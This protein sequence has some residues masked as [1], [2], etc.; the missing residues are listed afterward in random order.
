M[1]GPLSCFRPSENEDQDRNTT[2]LTAKRIRGTA[3]RRRAAYLAVRTNQLILVSYATA[4]SDR[5]QLIDL[6]RRFRVMLI[7]DESHRVKRFR[8]DSWA[9][10]LL[11]IAKHA[12]VRMILSG[13]PMP[14]SGKDLYTQI[15][16]LWP[17][18]Q[19]TGP[20][21]TFG[22][23]LIKPSEGPWHITTIYISDAEVRT[24]TRTISCRNSRYS[25]HRHAGRDISTNRRRI[26]EA[27]GRRRQLAR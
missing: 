15:N 21:D 1:V 16:I 6:C 24:W 7:V 22:A 27:S 26:P 12:R 3:A 19:L 11:E 18:G 2:L 17:A 14:Q 9:P 10:A 13:T 5:L 8:G 25:Y 20:R 4:A 23:R